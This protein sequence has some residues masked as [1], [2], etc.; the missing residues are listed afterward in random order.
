MLK[1]L[2]FTLMIA[3]FLASG[4]TLAPAGG[5][6]GFSFHGLAMAPPD[7]QILPVSEAKR[8]SKTDREDKPDS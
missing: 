7:H 1:A 5:Q 3:T 6:T 2:A 8:P 4:F